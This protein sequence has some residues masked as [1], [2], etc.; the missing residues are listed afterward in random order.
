[1]NWSNGLWTST[2]P[3]P[4]NF[5]DPC[6]VERWHGKGKKVA[7]GV[8][9]NTDAARALRCRPVSSKVGETK[10]VGWK[11]AS[12]RNFRPLYWQQGPPHM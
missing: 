5:A 6:N 9:Y 2:K 10:K 1:M 11:C 3:L 4:N 8:S 7:V 12:E